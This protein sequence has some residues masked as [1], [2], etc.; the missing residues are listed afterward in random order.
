MCWFCW[1]WRA[2]GAEDKLTRHVHLLFLLYLITMKGKM[3]ST[4]LVKNTIVFHFLHGWN[5]WISVS[6]HF[7]SSGSPSYSIKNPDNLKWL[8]KTTP[9]RLKLGWIA[10]CI[11]W[12]G[13]TECQ[14]LNADQSPP[15]KTKNNTLETHSAYHKCRQRTTYSAPV[16][17]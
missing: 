17:G 3:E 9:W 6:K 13:S 5:F 8:A 10:F 12:I 15:R 7:I 4:W 14:R 11:Q 16:N 1:E 2:G